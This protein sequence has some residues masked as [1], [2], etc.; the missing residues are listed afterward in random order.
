MATG[1]QHN[2]ND[3]VIYQKSLYIF[4]LVRHIASYITDDQN[5]MELYTSSSKSD[6]YADN[7][8]MNALGLVPKIV[9]TEIQENPYLKL[10]YAKSL[11]KFI[12]GIYH[13]CVRLERLKIN[14]TDFIKILRLE[15]KKMRKIHRHYVKS[16]LM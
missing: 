2:L 13:N 6:K 15:L 3:L 11:R 10:K 16:I 4:K 8:V 14:G 9:E 12:D 1:Y 7:L 5:M